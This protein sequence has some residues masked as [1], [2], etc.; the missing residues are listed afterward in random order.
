MGFSE[1]NTLTQSTMQFLISAHCPRYA[2]IY[3]LSSVLIVTWIQQASQFLASTRFVWALARDN[4]FPFANVWRQLSAKSRTPRRAAVLLVALTMTFSFFLAV[5]NTHFTIVVMRSDF[6]LSSLGYLI[7]IALYLLCDK[8][9]LNRDG[10]N[11]WTL[12]KWSRPLAYLVLLLGILRLFLGAF[13]LDSESIGRQFPARAVST[14]SIPG[15][16]IMGIV[17]WFVYGRRHYVGPIKSISVW[18]TGQ[19]VEIPRATEY[20]PST[21][22]NTNTDDAAR[23]RA[24]I[25]EE[26]FPMQVTTGS[27]SRGESG[28]VSSANFSKSGTSAATSG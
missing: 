11:V 8:D 17:A 22:A 18:T 7:P 28:P 15:I 12:Q 4:A 27:G 5:P 9:V 20:P 21:E 26:S 1:R 24:V 25:C 2:T 6:Y 13:P 3:I 16:T 14:V 23:A 10:R 19:E